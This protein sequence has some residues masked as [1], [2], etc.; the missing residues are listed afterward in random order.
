MID[1]V[2]A[3]L[4]AHPRHLPCRLLYD[5]RGAELFEQICTLP[6]YYLTRNELV[7]L[8]DH[9]PAIARIAGRHARVIEPGS[10]AAGKTRLLLSALAEPASYVAIDV[11]GEQLEATARG[12]RAAYPG[13]EVQPVHADFTI[14]DALPASR[15]ACARSLV[16]FPGSTIGN[17][18]PEA[19]RAFLAR[20]RTLA[21]PG[22]LLLLGADSNADPTS[23]VAA[24][25]DAQGVTAAFDLNVLAHVN[26]SHGGTF[27]LD[28]FRHRAVWD[29]RRSRI[30]MHLV[31]RCD[32]TVR[33]AGEVFAFA[34][35]EPIVT[36][37]CYKYSPEMVAG[38]LAEAGWRI[39]D[40]FG[41]PDGRMRLWLA[42]DAGA[43]LSR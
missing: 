8:R 12:L 20:F 21:G 24:Y 17:F 5:P 18:E 22:G 6:E 7:L 19:A 15:A 25:D 43:T 2:L 42:E 11:S 26:R 40:V 34:A 29:P 31:S 39:R 41:D 9:L 37:H 14:V 10:G 3:G 33:V 30:E 38:L 16:F 36:E 27:E 32:H 4:R 35:D 28:R 1:D 13:L 23:L